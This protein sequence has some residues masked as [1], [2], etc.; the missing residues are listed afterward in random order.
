[1]GHVSFEATTNDF[2]SLEISCRHWRT[3]RLMLK[4]VRQPTRFHDG[5]ARAD[6]YQAEEAGDPIE[7][8]QMKLLG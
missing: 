4:A 5:F 8:V 2:V 7:L 1:M 3:I 6:G